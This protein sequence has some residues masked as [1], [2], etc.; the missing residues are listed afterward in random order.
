MGILTLANAAGSLTT[1]THVAQA[2][3]RARSVVEELF[4]RIATQCWVMRLTV[5]RR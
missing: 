4:A 5:F 3:S 1:I 2:K